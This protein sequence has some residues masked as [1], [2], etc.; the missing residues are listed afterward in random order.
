MP[1]STSTLTANMLH[2]LIPACYSTYSNTLYLWAMVSNVGISQ[3]IRLLLSNMLSGQVIRYSIGD[4]GDGRQCL[5]VLLQDM[6]ESI[7]IVDTWG[8][9]YLHHE[10]CM[11]GIEVRRCQVQNALRDIPI[12]NTDRLHDLEYTRKGVRDIASRYCIS[13]WHNGHAGGV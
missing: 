5:S 12:V 11:K 8:V 4:E 6:L 2:T 10:G 3:V 7:P 13:L 1:H 9:Q